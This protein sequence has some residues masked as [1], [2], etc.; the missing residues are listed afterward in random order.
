VFERFRDAPAFRES[1]TSV[2]RQCSVICADHVVELHG[3]VTRGFSR[4]ETVHD[5][6]VTNPLAACS[7]FHHE[8]SREPELRLMQA[9]YLQKECSFINA[10]SDTLP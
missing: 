3:A 9:G 6:R 7:L 1:Q 5:E 8:R 2:E 10:Y 4:I